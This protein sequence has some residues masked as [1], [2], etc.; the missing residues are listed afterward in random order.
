MESDKYDIDQSSDV[1]DN[2]F[3]IIGITQPLIKEGEDLL[4]EIDTIVYLLDTNNVHYIHLRKPSASINNLKELLER[5]P[6]RLHH[7]ITLHDT[8]SL[9]EVYNIGGLH[10]N[11]RTD[12]SE[13]NK[14]S[15]QKLHRKDGEKMRLSRSFHTIEELKESTLPLDYATLSPIFDSISKAG[16]HSRFDIDMLCNILPALNIPVIALGSSTTQTFYPLRESGFAGAAM[17]GYFFK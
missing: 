15:T 9:A 7:R 4:S 8:F 5:I 10:I 14:L 17:L 16:Y 6:T 13:L 3:L 2:Q 11:S 1:M 12:E